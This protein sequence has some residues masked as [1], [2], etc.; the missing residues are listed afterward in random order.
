MFSSLTYYER[1]KRKKAINIMYMFILFSLGNFKTRERRLTS[2]AL[3]MTDSH[4][5]E[6]IHQMTYRSNK[7]FFST[8]LVPS[9][10]TRSS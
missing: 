8:T 5:I 2:S 1:K 7:S 4:I 10:L 9:T 3:R 6:I